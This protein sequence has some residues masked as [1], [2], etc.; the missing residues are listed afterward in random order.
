MKNRNQISLII[1]LVVLAVAFTWISGIFSQSGNTVPYSQ[2][3]SLFR[4]EQVKSFTVQGDVLTL[5]LHSPYNG[6]STVSTSL[7]DP[8]GFREDMKELF[9]AQTEAGILTSYDFIARDDSSPY[10]IVLPL[11]IV[12]YWISTNYV[13]DMWET[14]KTGRQLRWS[15]RWDT[16]LSLLRF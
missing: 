10:D 7:A 11:L 8:E 16:T 14:K 15:R 5:R 13:Q 9:E 2:V 12:G 6:E 3:V 1:Y 4:Q